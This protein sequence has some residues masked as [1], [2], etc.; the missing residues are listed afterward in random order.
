MLD[1]ETESRADCNQSTIDNELKPDVLAEVQYL[2]SNW[3]DDFEKQQ[4]DGKTV[5]QLLG[6]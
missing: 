3:L 2:A 4:F 5:R 6:E 1:I